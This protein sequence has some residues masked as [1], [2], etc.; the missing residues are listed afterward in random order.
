MYTEKD[1]DALMNCL[2][3]SLLEED[4]TIPIAAAFEDCLLLLVTNALSDDNNAGEDVDTGFTR[5]QWKCIALSKLMQLS[6]CAKRYVLKIL[7]KCC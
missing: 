4:L 2:S 7:I 3:R 1:L 6:V 5:Y